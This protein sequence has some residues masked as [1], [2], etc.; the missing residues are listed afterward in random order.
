MTIGERIKCLRKLNGLSQRKLTKLTDYRN[1]HSL[2]RIE[3]EQCNPSVN[4]TEQLARALDTNPCFLAGWAPADKPADGDTIGSRI[5]NLREKQGMTQLE[6]AERSNKCLDTILR[7]ED[8]AGSNLTIALIESV[9]A[10]LDTAPAT[11]TGWTDT[12]NQYIETETGIVA[13]PEKKTEIELTRLRSKEPSLTVLGDRVRTARAQLGLSQPA[14]AAKLGHAT[15]TNVALIEAGKRSITP[16]S[17]DIVMQISKIL[18]VPPAKLLGWDSA[19]FGEERTFG[20]RLKDY[21]TSR[22]MTLED[23]ACKLSVSKAAVG[24]W[25]A[26]ITLSAGLKKIEKLARALRVTP[27]Y[28]LGWEDT[29]FQEQPRTATVSVELPMTVLVNNHMTEEDMAAYAEK[30]AKEY[31]RRIK[32]PDLTF[33]GVRFTDE[34]PYAE[35][36]KS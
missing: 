31:I 30:R 14:L 29:D 22:G 26:D 18:N 17:L 7:L 23:L 2:S 8:N 11:I 25:E 24:N 19:T 9:A 27:A 36:V 28:I 13:L 33:A 6:L 12:R 34:N 16:H 1:Y 10:A 4:L 32:A 20:E 3:T 21:R 35:K 15:R 5:R